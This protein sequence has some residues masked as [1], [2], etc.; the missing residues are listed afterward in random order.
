MKKTR[1]FSVLSYVTWIGWLVAYFRSDRSEHM[2]QH[3]LNQALVLN[4]LVTVC[5]ILTSNSGGLLHLI[6]ELGGLVALVLLILGIVRA[7][8][9]SDKPLPLIGEIQIL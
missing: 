3:H 1:L 9:L 5:N 4:I 2:V 7:A 8:R 6:G